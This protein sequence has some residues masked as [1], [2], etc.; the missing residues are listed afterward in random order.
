MVAKR[1]ALGWRI[2]IHH[3]FFLNQLNKATWLYTKLSHLMHIL[4]VQQ[5]SPSTNILK[6]QIKTMSNTRR[7]IVVFMILRNQ[8]PYGHIICWIIN[9][10][11]N[12]IEWTNLFNHLIKWLKQISCILNNIWSINKFH[13]WH[14]LRT[15]NKEVNECSLSVVCPTITYYYTLNF[16]LNFTIRVHK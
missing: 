3:S 4:Q 6:N 2:S 9:H 15:I 7:P 14:S 11:M 10:Y 8:S 16:F 13:K 12:Y 1:V 5:H